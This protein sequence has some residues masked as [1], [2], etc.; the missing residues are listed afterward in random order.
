MSVPLYSIR[1]ATLIDVPLLPEIEKQAAR[2]FKLTRHS[3]F[4]DAP[5][6]AADIDLEREWV[7]VVADFDNAPVGFAI[8]RGYGHA[9]HIQE[10]DVHPAHA[11]RG[12]GRMLIEHVAQWA[13]QQDVAALTLTTFDD[14][15]WNAPYYAR[16]GFRMLNIDALPPH[17]RTIREYE[18]AHRFPMQHR[19]CMQLDLQTANDAAIEF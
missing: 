5:L 3:E 10:I 13:Q 17:L 8:V 1:A 9:L 2:L 14:V 19:V 18:A 16:L 7:W 11:R 12:L 4:A 15:P 6:A